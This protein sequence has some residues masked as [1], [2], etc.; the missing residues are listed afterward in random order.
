MPLHALTENDLREYC[1][2]SIEALELWLRGLIDQQ[3]T[4]EYGT[5]YI[6][7]VRTNGDRVIRGEISRRL[8]ERT[9]D[10]LRFPRPIDGALLDDLVDIVCNPELYNS[11]FKG[12]LNDVF[13]VGCQMART[14]LSRLISPR[15]AL[16]HANPV[17]IQEALRILC[18]S[19]DVI[20]ALKA[21]YQRRGL[22][23]QFN[24]R[25]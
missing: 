1:K 24:M 15:N 11:H 12:P 10:K 8:I 5:D 9:S 23:Q 17:S 20:S 19:E 13:P 18:Y 22:H 14:I 2:R 6:N 7:A 4:N 3:L 25:W 16:Y 21:D